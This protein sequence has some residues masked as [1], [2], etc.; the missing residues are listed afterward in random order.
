[1]TIQSEYISVKCPKNVDD[2]EKYLGEM[3]I[4]G[5]LFFPLECALWLMSEL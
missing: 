4:S 1:M 3:L 5:V 2:L